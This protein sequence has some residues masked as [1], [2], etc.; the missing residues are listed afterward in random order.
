MLIQHDQVLYSYVMCFT[1]TPSADNPIPGSGNS[2]S[3]LLERLTASSATSGSTSSS[4]YTPLPSTSPNNQP[5]TSPASKTQFLS[6][7]TSPN[8]PQQQQTHFTSPSPKPPAT[9]SPLSSPPQSSVNL[10]L[11]GLS[12]ASLQGAMASIPGLQNVQ[13]SAGKKYLDVTEK[14]RQNN[15]ENCFMKFFIRY[16]LH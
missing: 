6:Q 8:N 2:A 7:S 3:S 15:G 14:K 12:L 9:P 5:F 10:N 16:P 1:G 13:V 4:P 11:Q